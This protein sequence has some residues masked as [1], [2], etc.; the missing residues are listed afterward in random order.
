MNLSDLD[1]TYNPALRDIIAGRI[2]AS[3]PISFAEFYEL[4]MYHPRHGYYFTQDPTRDFQSSPNVHPVFGACIARQ[5][6]EFWRDLDQPAALRRLRG[7]RRIRPARRRHPAL[8]RTAPNP[9]STL[10]L[11]YVVQDVTLGGADA[12]HRLEAAHPARRQGRG[13]RVTARRAANRRLHPQQRAAGR[14]AL[15]PPAQP[16]RPALRAARGPED[17]AFVDV[18]AEPRPDIAAHFAGPRR[19]AP[20]TGCEAEVIL[21]APAWMAHAAERPAPRLPPD[22]RLRLRGAPTCTPPGASAAPC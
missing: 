14:P 16:R 12:H 2:E 4:A 6:A 20:V 21:A 1:A 19:R 8:R 9:S 22:A 5:L 7:R 10:A 3:G 11:R 18:E 13:R 15:S 17:G